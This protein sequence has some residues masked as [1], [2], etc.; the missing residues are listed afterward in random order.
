MVRRSSLTENRGSDGAVSSGDHF[1]RDVTTF[2]IEV[3]IGACVER[4][5]TA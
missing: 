3:Q 4:L 5:N 1:C 2:G